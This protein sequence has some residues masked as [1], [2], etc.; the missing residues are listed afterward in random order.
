[1]IWL[2]A[3]SIYYY[4][5]AK[6]TNKPER[7]DGSTVLEFLMYSYVYKCLFKHYK[8]TNTAARFLC[9]RGNDNTK[10]IR[11]GIGYIL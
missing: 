2:C 8:L 7:D 11:S 3:D 4:N 9:D 6:Y 5:K 10:K 1:M